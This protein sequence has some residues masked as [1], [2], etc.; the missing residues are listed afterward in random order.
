MPDWAFHRHS[1]IRASMHVHCPGPCCLTKSILH[2]HVHVACSCQCCIP[3]QCIMSMSMS[4][5]IYIEMSECRCQNARLSS[6]WSV[7]YWTEKTN[8]AKTSMVQSGIF[9]V[10]YCSETMLT[11]ESQFLTSTH[12]GIWTWVP[13]DRKQTGCPLDQWDMVRKKWDCR[14]SRGLPP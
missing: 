13:C 5:D 8:D 3:C 14:L 6:I 1:G 2:V 11:G 9:L 12:L 7:R 10:Q 4:I